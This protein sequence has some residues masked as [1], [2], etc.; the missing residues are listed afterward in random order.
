M[1]FDIVLIP[2]ISVLFFVG[3]VPYGFWRRCAV[4]SVRDPPLA[5]AAPLAHVLY[6]YVERSVDWNNHG[7]MR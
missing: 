3:F 6:Q 5:P 7:E 1:T 2:R 4:S